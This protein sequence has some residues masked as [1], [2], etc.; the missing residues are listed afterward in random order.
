MKLA[1]KRLGPVTE[2]DQQRLLDQVEQAKENIL[3]RRVTG[4]AIAMS[5]VDGGVGT[6]FTRANVGSI[7]VL[8]GA[9]SQLG[10]RIA[11]VAR[12]K[13]DD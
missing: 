4:L 6:G 13:A 12:K 3:S 8:A 10:W 9:V 1:E 5:Y 7:F 2:E 11:E